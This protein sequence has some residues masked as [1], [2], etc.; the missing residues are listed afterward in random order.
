MSTTRTPLT[1]RQT[2][3]VLSGLLLGMFLAGLDQTIVFTAA[4]TIGDDLGGLDQQAWLT[5]AFLLTSTITTLLYGKFSDIF[6]RKRLYMLA[7]A[8]FLL[9]S[10]LCGFATSM[11][12]LAGFRAV[13]GLGAGGLMSLAFAIVGDIMPPRERAR[14]QGY[15]AATMALSSVLGPLAGGF[16]AGMPTLLGAA[17]WRWAFWINIPI[18]I[19]ALL[20]ISATLHVDQ[21]QKS[22]R[23]D[24]LGALLLPVAI[25]PALLLGE[26][27]AIWGWG[28]LAAI[29]CYVLIALGTAAFIIRQRRM[30]DDALLPLDLFHSRSFTIP[31]LLM[32]V[33]GVVQLGG[34]A[35]VP[36]YLQIVQGATPTQAGLLMLPMV[37]GI[38]GASIV[39]GQIAARTGKYKMLPV[40]GM[41]L[42]VVAF[43]GL[44]TVSATTS[45]ILIN[46]YMLILGIGVGLS[47]NTVMLA[48]QSAGGTQR[49][50]IA[51]ASGTFFRN[52]GG[53]AGTALLLSV[54]FSRA[55]TNIAANYDAAQTDPA[56]LAAQASHPE[57]ASQLL[58]GLGGGLSDT[59]FLTGL[60]STLAR[61]FLDGFT[62][63]MNTTAIIAAVVSALGL[64]L[65][66]FI[67]NK[68]LDAAPSPTQ[69]QAQTPESTINPTT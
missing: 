11:P 24:W 64:T 28:S 18:G 8:L 4:R 41:I 59:N 51:T 15:F 31:T 12:M 19:V 63:A 26:E 23:I 29:G 67:R 36:L 34:I 20:I 54:L 56:F 30:G 44:A 69:A 5:T 39:A 62:S 55:S 35:I 32:F 60:N 48:L 50:G 1:Y 53:T 37:L 14:Y 21:Q 61:P 42:L 66:L 57:Q 27:G 2:L 33:L 38:S 45:L 16:F 7:I 52:I 13:Q 10:L 17:G 68:S 3:T 40:T 46:A 47:M 58:N 22:P 65:A 9:G 43:I 6:G 25:V 49:M